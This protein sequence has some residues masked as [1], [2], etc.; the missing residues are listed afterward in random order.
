MYYFLI[1]TPLRLAEVA[2]KRILSDYVERLKMKIFFVT[3]AVIPYHIGDVHLP[4]FFLNAFIFL[5]NIH[6]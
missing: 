6:F 2:R 3:D 5:A 4:T 1:F